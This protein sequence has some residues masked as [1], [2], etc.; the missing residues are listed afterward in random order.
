MLDQLITDAQLNLDF[1]MESA[2][3]PST[4]EKMELKLKV[5]GLGE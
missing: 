5:A 2:D 3:M 4:T 1:K